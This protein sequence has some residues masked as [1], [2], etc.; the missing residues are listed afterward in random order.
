VTILIAPLLLLTHAKICW[1]SALMGASAKVTTNAP[2]IPDTRVMMFLLLRSFPPP[3]F[4]SNTPIAASRV[5]Y[6]EVVIVPLAWWAGGEGALE[7]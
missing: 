4:G 6:I 1:A 2:A 3:A 5:A 7:D